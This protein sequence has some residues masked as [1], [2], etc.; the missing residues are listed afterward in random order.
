MSKMTLSVSG[1]SFVSVSF[2]KRIGLVVDTKSFFERVPSK[3]KMKIVTQEAYSTFIQFAE[4]TNGNIVPWIV[5][6]TDP[7]FG[8]NEVK[9]AEYVS[10]KYIQNRL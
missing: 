4:N 5:S 7:M 6:E 3:H 10:R 1:K 8:N 2:L 9:P